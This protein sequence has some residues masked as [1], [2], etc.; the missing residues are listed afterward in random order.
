MTY[1]VSVLFA[2]LAED[3]FKQIQLVLCSLLDAPP[4][5]SEVTSWE[6]HSARQI[7][8]GE[9][10][11]DGSPKPKVQLCCEFDHTFQHQP[12]QT[13]LFLLSQL[14]MS[15]FCLVSS[16]PVLTQL[17]STWPT[18]GKVS[19]HEHQLVILR[20]GIALVAMLCADSKA[21]QFA[22]FPVVRIGDVHC[23]VA[24]GQYC[25]GRRCASALDIRSQSW[26]KLHGGRA[27]PQSAYDMEG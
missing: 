18:L 27:L 23:R 17:H 19:L 25:V 16:H 11:N 5:P 12:M 20:T 7:R 6:G 26:T 2:A 3:R 8:R 22:L 14:S 24:P 4:Q 21:V 15:F 13:V 1:I 9:S 10:R